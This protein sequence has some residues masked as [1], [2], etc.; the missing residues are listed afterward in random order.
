MCLSHSLLLGACSL[1]TLV[2]L[3]PTNSHLQCDVDKRRIRHERSLPL[4]DASLLGHQGHNPMSSLVYR[5]SLES[6]PNTW[7][8]FSIQQ[9]QFLVNCEGKIPL[10]TRILNP[11]DPILTKKLTQ[12]GPAGPNFTTTSQPVFSLQNIA[13]PRIFRA[14]FSRDILGTNESNPSFSVFSSSFFSNEPFAMAFAR[15]LVWSCAFPLLRLASQRASFHVRVHVRTRP[16]SDRKK[17][18]SETA[19]GRLGAARF[20]PCRD[21]RGATPRGDGRVWG[22]MGGHGIAPGRTRRV[23]WGKTGRVRLAPGVGEG[24]RSDQV[25]EYGCSKAPP[26]SS[27]HAFG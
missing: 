9:A 7:V 20:A 27:A 26:A 25:E 14:P 16:R 24:P 23:V 12:G 2:Q 5:V 8:A 19:L 13:F 10:C 1:V 15:A 22:V 21:R 3:Q 4:R 11:P 6:M 17:T 18:A